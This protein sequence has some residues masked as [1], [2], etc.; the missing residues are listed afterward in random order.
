MKEGRKR[1]KKR[2]GGEEECSVEIFDLTSNFV[3]FS[4]DG[5]LRRNSVNGVHSHIPVQL[6]H[7]LLG[8]GERK[9]GC[10]RGG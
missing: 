1:R 3:S 10:K 9:H 2:E 8:L 6:A 7:L 4:E 5:D